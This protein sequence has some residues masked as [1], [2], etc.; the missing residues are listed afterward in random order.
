MSGLVIQQTLVLGILMVVGAACAKSGIL[1]KERSQGIS[2][3]LINVTLPA[4]VVQKCLITVTPQQ[5]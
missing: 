1:N 4:M 3:L 2:G 5:L